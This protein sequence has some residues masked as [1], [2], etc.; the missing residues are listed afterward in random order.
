MSHIHVPDYA[1]NISDKST[2][3]W[4]TER[5][6][7]YSSDIPMYLYTNISLYKSN[8]FVD[9]WYS[10]HHNKGP[11]PTLQINHL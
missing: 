3:Y 7:K 9:N 2:K 5:W 6:Y 11:W 10:V 8:T 4:L 1:K